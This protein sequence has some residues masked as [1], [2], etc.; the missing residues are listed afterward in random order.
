M[1]Y[2]R[3]EFISGARKRVYLALKILKEAT[4]AKITSYQLKT[5]LL[6]IFRRQPNNMRIGEAILKV[7]SKEANFK[8]IKDENVHC[9]GDLFNG[10]N[11][12]LEKKGFDR[13]DLS[14]LED[15]VVILKKKKTN[16]IK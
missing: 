1:P 9:V 11:S 13:I 10:L 15:D 8:S 3:E 5:D 7:F 12:N 4:G 2:L 14:K 6:K 16:R